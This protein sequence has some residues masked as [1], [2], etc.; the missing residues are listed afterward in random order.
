MSVLLSAAVFALASC[1]SDHSSDVLSQEQFASPERTHYPETWFHFIGNNVSLE[2]ITLDLEAIASAGLSGVQFFHGQFGGTWPEVG[3]GIAPL[4]ENWD[5]AVQH[6]AKECQRLGLDFTIQNCPGWAMSGGPWI[7]PENAMRTIV[8]SRVDV[9]GT[10]VDM[11]LPMPER[12]SEDWRDYRDIAVLAFPTPKGDT[13]A[14]LEF[15]SVRGDDG[16]PWEK[17]MRGESGRVNFPPA[18]DEPHW[19]EVGFHEPVTVRTFEFPSIN[20]LNHN[21][22]YEPGI[23]L[24]VYAKTADGKEHLIVDAPVPQ[25][26]WQDDDPLTFACPEVEDAVACRIEIDNK[27]SMNL[28]RMR[29]YSA[30]RK[31]SWESEAGLTLRS[32]ER[33]AD[34]LVQSR[35]AY[36]QAEGICDITEHMSADGRLAW[37]APSD[38]NWTILRIGHVNAGEKNGP[39]PVEGTGWECDKLSTE[40]PEAHFAGYVGRLAEGALSGEGL[41]DAEISSL[42]PEKCASK[43]SSICE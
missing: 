1:S 36:I 7:K 38:C 37:T 35:D 42:Q 10:Q 30:A 22:N 40:G 34:D 14:S 13:G 32:F 29:L 5:D 4:S 19:V 27:H 26:N 6:I 39:A 25:A 3:E 2:G 28:G 11:N 18:G 24:K 17:L 12:T 43:R 41:L 33:T 8:S 23:D 31:N 9:S 21:M 16:F 15:K 20:S